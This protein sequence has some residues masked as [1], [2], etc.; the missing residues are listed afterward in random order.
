MRLIGTDL[1][2][3]IGFVSEFDLGS[4]LEAKGKHRLTSVSKIGPSNFSLC[5]RFSQGSLRPFK[6]DQFLLI[7]LA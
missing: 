6:M 3:S 1:T 4:G 5:P 7:R 2:L